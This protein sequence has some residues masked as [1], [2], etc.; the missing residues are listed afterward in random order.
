M[1]SSREKTVLNEKALKAVINVSLL[2]L[3]RNSQIIQSTDHTHIILSILVHA[4][5]LIKATYCKLLSWVH[6]TLKEQVGN[7]FEL[8]IPF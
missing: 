7:T 1:L 5:M 2:Y 8:C 6:G 3:W 4:E